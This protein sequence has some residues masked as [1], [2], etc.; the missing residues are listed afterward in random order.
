MKNIMVDLE[1]FGR[2]P[3]GAIVSIGAVEFDSHGIKD[4]YYQ[5]ILPSS[6]TNMGMNINPETIDW[7]LQQ[8]K[9]AQNALF[10]GDRIDLKDALVTFCFWA[11]KDDDK[12][13]TM[14]ANGVTY[15]FAILR[16][17]F[18]LC[19]LTNSHVFW[20]YRDEMC[21]R[22]LRK[23]GKGLGLPYEKDKE[24]AHNALY[25]AKVQAEYVIALYKKLGISL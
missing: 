21:M 25:D 11:M 17:A 23:I 14:W 20:T 8:S 10:E 15:D 6:A 24:K 12:K 1:C 16:K 3:Y 19:K 2:A 7:W 5:N 22:S 4:G 13:Y 18:D 9:E